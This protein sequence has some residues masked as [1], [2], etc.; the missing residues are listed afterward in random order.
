MKHFAVLIGGA[1]LLSASQASAADMHHGGSMKDD[2]V[3]SAPFNWTG[4][5]IGV[6]AGYQW[7][8]SDIGHEYFLGFDPAKSETE[9]DGFVGGV[10][11]GYNAQRSRFVF[12]VEADIEYVDSDD[13]SLSIPYGPGHLNTLEFNYQ[14]SIRSRLGVASGKTL[15]YATAGVAFADVDYNYDDP[16]PEYD[17]SGSKTFVGYTV[18]AGVEH[19]FSSNWTARLEYRF[20]DFGD[21][22]FKPNDKTLGNYN[23]ELDEVHAVRVG[24]SYK[25][26]DRHEALK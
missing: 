21:E 24:V 14:A 15:Y 10:H 16:F 3:Y 9:L 25:L 2:A 8:D 13:E 7:G 1:L 19:A 4:F 6:Q 18:G 17:A 5:Y 22:N 12:G 20:T 26:G 11:I 23:V